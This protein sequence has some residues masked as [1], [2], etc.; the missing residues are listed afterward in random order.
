[1][2]NCSCVEEGRPSN[3]RARR[4]TRS[5]RIDYDL[6]DLTIDI[7]SLPARVEENAQRYCEAL[8]RDCWKT[9]ALPTCRAESIGKCLACSPAAFGAPSGRG[10]RSGVER[11]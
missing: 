1:M 5:P 4:R 10:R 7:A 3:H 8:G 9:C 11:D 2:R 6:I